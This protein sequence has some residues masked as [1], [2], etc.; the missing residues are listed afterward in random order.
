[1][2]VYFLRPARLFVFHFLFPLESTHFV[3]YGISNLS[4]RR[5]FFM[6]LGRSE[7]RLAS[8]PWKLANQKG[9]F[10]E[11]GS[12]IN[13]IPV[14]ICS[15]LGWKVRNL[16]PTKIIVHG[17]TDTAQITL[18]YNMLQM[19][20]DRWEAYI[21]WMLLMLL[22]LTIFDWG[23]PPLILACFFVL[24]YCLVNYCELFNGRKKSFFLPASHPR[25]AA[26]TNKVK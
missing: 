23:D 1:M 3:T 2:K 15:A 19:P 6:C 17:V 13:R 7:V 14:R 24:G 22:L 21:Q 10:L 5:E 16:T 12:S 25:G 4:R 18:G 9:A 8:P 26:R 20:V 11:N